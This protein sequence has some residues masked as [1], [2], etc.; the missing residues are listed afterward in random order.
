MRP[1]SSIDGVIVTFFTG[2]HLRIPIFSRRSVDSHSPYISQR[3]SP[4]NLLLFL[5]MYLVEL[6]P[7]SVPDGEVEAYV[8]IKQTMGLLEAYSYHNLTIVQRKILVIVYELG[9]GFLTAASISLGSCTR[10]ARM[11]GLEDLESLR[12]HPASSS[13]MGEESR[14]A[15]CAIFLLDRFIN[16]CTGDTMFG[17]SNARM[18]DRLPS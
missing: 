2:T 17:M 1:G 8:L 6:G 15:W 11:T 10:A 16:L 18:T 12:E 14:R 5:A 9:H 13:R 3:T 7:P 4:E